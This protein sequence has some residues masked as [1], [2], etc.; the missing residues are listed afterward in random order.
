M[1]LPDP[2]LKLRRYK[3]PGLYSDHAEVFPDAINVVLKKPGDG[4][5]RR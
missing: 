4:G 2:R 5:D 1:I 3:A